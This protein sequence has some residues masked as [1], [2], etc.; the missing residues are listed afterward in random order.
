MPPLARGVNDNKKNL[1]NVLKNHV[2]AYYYLKI[3]INNYKK[4]W[5][6]NGTTTR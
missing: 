2:D 6:I 1:Q 4:K 5:K 3:R